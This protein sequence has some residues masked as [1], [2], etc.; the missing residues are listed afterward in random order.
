MATSARV[1]AI[2]A[3]SEKMNALIVLLLKKYL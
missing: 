1:N 3:S 2:N